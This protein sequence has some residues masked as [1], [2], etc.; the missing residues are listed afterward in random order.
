MSKAKLDRLAAAFETRGIPVLSNLRPGASDAALDGLATELGVVLPSQLRD[1]YSWRNGHSHPEASNVLVFRDNT[2]M[3]LDEIPRVRQSVLDLNLLGR[4]C[5]LGEELKGSLS[6]E[7]RMQARC[8]L[9][10]TES[11]IGRFWRQRVY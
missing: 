8:K 5:G 1:L 2:F 3:G 9:Q 11:C 7:S 6:T 10:S 4:G